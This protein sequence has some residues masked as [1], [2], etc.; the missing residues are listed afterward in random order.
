MIPVRTR[1]SNFIYRGNG[2]DVE[3]VWVERPYSGVAI[4][5][6]KPSDEERAAIAA[7]ANIDL[8]IGTEP[9]PPTDLHVSTRTELS[10]SAGAIR[11]RALVEVARWGAK[12]GK[13]ADSNVKGWW[14]VSG[15][16]FDDMVAS[17]ALDPDSDAE[18]PMLFG[19]PVVADERLVTGSLSF[20]ENRLTVLS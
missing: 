10:A 14:S 19:Q 9:I 1:G 15:D 20:N 12:T 2:H 5:T 17:E 18:S 6:W 16:V 4:L 11:D 13:A 8:V 7:G 3:E